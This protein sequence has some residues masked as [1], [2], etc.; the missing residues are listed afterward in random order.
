MVTI[1]NSHYFPSRPHAGDVGRPFTVNLKGVIHLSVAAGRV[2]RDQGA[3]GVIVHIASTTAF[4]PLRDTSMYSATKAALAN[5][6]QSM[7][8][9]LGEF[10]IRVVAIAPG[11]IWT[12]TYE[13]VRQERTAT[14]GHEKLVGQAVLGQGQPMD[15]GEVVAFVASPRARY[16]TG[17]TLRVDGG[18]LA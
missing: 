8:T 4:R 12:D 5:L 2:M 7:A 9:E 14:G 3:G 1:E 16:I 6:A 11:D 17:T 10:G 13:K 15:I 18:L